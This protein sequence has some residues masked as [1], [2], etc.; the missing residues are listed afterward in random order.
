MIVNQGVPPLPNAADWSPELN[1]FYRL[2]TERDART[3]PSPAD[4]LRVCSLSVCV[5]CG[6]VCVIV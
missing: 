4:L 1:A 2:C 6:S 3:R 5:V